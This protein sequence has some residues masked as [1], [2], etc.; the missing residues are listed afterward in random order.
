MLLVMGLAAPGARATPAP[1]PMSAPALVAAP[2][3]AAAP[4][5]DAASTLAMPSGAPEEPT[6]LAPNPPT[7]RSL[8]LSAA[9]TVGV[10]AGAL[11]YGYNT[12]QAAE[13][14]LPELKCWSDLLDPKLKDEVQV[15]DPNSSGTS[16]TLLATMVL[17]PSRVLSSS[18]MRSPRA[19][20][21]A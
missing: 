15:A 19:A 7:H 2:E 16:Y 14:K 4:A 8:V 13:K 3:G 10:Y 17:G 21:S 1:P 18:V 9:G 5:G 12:K 11:G 6:P 20:S